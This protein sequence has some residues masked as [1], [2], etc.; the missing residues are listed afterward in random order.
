MLNYLKLR[1]KTNTSPLFL[2]SENVPL[3]KSC[4]NFYL[5]KSSSKANYPLSII[6]G[7]LS[8]LAPLL[9]LPIKVFHCHPCSNWGVGLHPHSPPT[10]TPTLT[11]FEQTKELSSLNFRSLL[12]PGKMAEGGFRHFVGVDGS[13]GML[14]QAAKTG[15]YEDLKLA[16]LGPEPLPAPTDT[17]DVVIIV[18]GMDAGFIPAS[19]VR[20][21]CDATKPGGFVCIS[22]G[23]HTAT[24]SIKYRKELERELQ[25]MEDEGLWSPVGVKETDKYMENPHLNAE[26]VKELQQE[27]R[28]IS[29]RVYLYKKSIN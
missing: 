6:Q 7:T 15:L 3:S 22:R 26:R 14:E 9:L 4:F 20:E 27:E 21:F 25:L 10:F 12:P 8:G 28:Y 23:D 13:K 11:P 16:L 29:G 19:V 24:P 1:P 17:F 18:G 2:I 5:T